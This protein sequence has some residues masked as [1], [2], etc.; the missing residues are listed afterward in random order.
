M[1]GI[2]E[3]GVVVMSESALKKLHELEGDTI[4]MGHNDHGH[5]HGAGPGHN[6]HGHTEHVHDNQHVLVL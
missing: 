4:P 3:T 5:G 2:N 1:F 6:D